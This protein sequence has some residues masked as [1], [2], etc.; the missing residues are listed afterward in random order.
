MNKYC[1]KFPEFPGKLAKKF[2]G[3]REK[4]IR[5]F[6]GIS[7]AGIPGKQTLHRT[8]QHF[9]KKSSLISSHFEAVLRYF[10]PAKRWR[11]RRTGDTQAAI[12]ISP[13]KLYWC[14]GWNVMMLGKM[15]KVLRWTWPQANPLWGRGHNRGIHIFF[16]IA[17]IFRIFAT[18]LENH[19]NSPIL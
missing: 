5:D 18:V 19:S 12:F 7:R 17:N 10:F 3:K 11:Q 14:P 9:S 2:P 16:Q 13:K 8:M 6:P 15:K 4:K 1:S